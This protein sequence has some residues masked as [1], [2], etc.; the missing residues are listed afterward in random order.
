V[1]ILPKIIRLRDAPIYLG[2]NKNHF[3][4]IRPYLTEIPIGDIGIGSD[5]LELYHWVD[6]TG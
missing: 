3:T 2:T 5:R 1:E 6:Y 4:Q